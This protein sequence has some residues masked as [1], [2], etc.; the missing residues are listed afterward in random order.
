MRD[1]TTTNNKGRLS[2]KPMIIPKSAVHFTADPSEKIEWPV[3]EIVEISKTEALGDLID[4]VTDSDI[5]DCIG[6][7][8][9]SNPFTV[10]IDGDTIRIG[11]HH[12]KLIP[13]RE[14]LLK[15]FNNWFK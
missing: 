13:A 7:P 5:R 1:E 3:L 9:A 6:K 15:K 10:E 14:N 4:D 2:M 8:W 12:E 11:V